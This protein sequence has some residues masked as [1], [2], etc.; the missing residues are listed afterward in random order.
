VVNNQRL[1]NFVVAH[2]EY[3]SPLGRRNVLT[4]LVAE[5]LPAD[6]PVEQFIVEQLAIDESAA[7][8][9]ARQP[10]AGDTANRGMLSSTPR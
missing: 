7:P 4:G 5:D 1:A 10:A 8:P 2:S 9:P 3:S 6:Q